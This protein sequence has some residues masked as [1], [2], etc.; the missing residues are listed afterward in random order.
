ME[1]FIAWYSG[2]QYEKYAFYNRIFGPYWWYWWVGM[3]FCNALSPQL[4]WF[5][6]CRHNIFVVYFV[7]MCVNAGM[8][9]E[10]FVIIVGGLHRDFLPS[11][12]GI[13]HADL[14]RHLDV[15]RHLR[16]LPLALPALHAFPA[17]DRD[18]GSEDRHAGSGPAS[19]HSGRTS[20]RR[21]RRKG[22]HMITPSGNRSLW[23]RRRS[24][25]APQLFTKR[26]SKCAMRAIKRWDVHSPFPIH[27]MDDAMG[28]GKSW[29]SAVVLA[30]ASPVFS[31]RVVLTFGPS[32]FHLSVDCAR[33]AV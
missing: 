7:C 20:C 16:N 2:N 28:L 13:I 4:F 30:A 24:I 5:K 23:N 31:P 3:I 11:S 29:L 22:A 18:V 26:R 19:R 14:G 1:L 21:G 10:R 33:K 6:W 25:Q 32:S 17:H 8:W 15:H 27:G 9:F 12:W